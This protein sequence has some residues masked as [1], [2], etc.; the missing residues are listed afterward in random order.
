LEQRRENLLSLKGRWA[1]P[2]VSLERFD[3]YHRYAHLI[4]EY[5]SRDSPLP[6]PTYSRPAVLIEE[7]SLDYDD[8]T[9][10]IACPRDAEE[11]DFPLPCDSVENI[12]TDILA[13]HAGEE[14]YD[15]GSTCESISGGFREGAII[16]VIWALPVSDCTDSQLCLSCC[17][18]E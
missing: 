14:D 17:G 5:L 7:P 10:D 1:N 9:T 6:F 15:D 12:F 4:T 16:P 8:S 3:S 11:Y 13:E 18:I 2:I